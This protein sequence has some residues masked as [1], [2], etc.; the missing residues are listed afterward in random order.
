MHSRVM[1]CKGAEMK[2]QN[3]LRASAFC[4]VPVQF[5]SSNQSC[6]L[7]LLTLV[8]MMQRTDANEVLATSPQGDL[9]ATAVDGGRIE[10]RS[11]SDRKNTLTLQHKGVPVIEERRLSAV[12]WMPTFVFSPDGAVLAS[13]CAWL[14]VTLWDVET[15]QM[16]RQFPGIGVGYELRFSA[17]GS[18]LIGSGILDKLG[19]QRLSL[20]NVATGEVLREIDVDTPLG[21]EQWDRNSIRPQFAKTGPMLVVELI[22]GSKRSLMGVNTKTNVQTLL[23]KLDRALPVHWAISTDGEYLILREYTGEQ[24]GV[25]RHRVIEMETG[26]TIQS[27]TPAIPP[28]R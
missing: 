22:N 20:W 6:L 21:N 8:S 12:S 19:R 26:Q 13:R 24:D 23:V 4:C 15:G 18:R 11:L 2:R 7:V 10:I 25:K 9:V 16:L 1:L 17:D 27:W 14:P 5:G 3:K 28:S